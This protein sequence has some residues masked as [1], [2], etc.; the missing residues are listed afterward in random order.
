MMMK[1][2]KLFDY[3]EDMVRRVLEAFKSLRSVMAQMPTGTGKTYL[4]AAI[5]RDIAGQQVDPCVWIVAHRRELV[6]QIE[7]TLARFGISTDEH[8]VKALSI[9]WLSR[10]IDEVGEEPGM[11]VIDEAHH[12]LAETY[13][14]LWDKFPKTKFLGLTATPCRLN[15]KGFTDLFDTLVASYTVG[16]FIQMGYL[17]PFDYVS[18]RPNSEEQRLVDSLVKR[19]ADGDFQT[20]EMAEVLNT[21]PSIERLYRS[22][23]DFAGD[24]KGIVYAINI[25]HAHSIAEYYLEHGINAVAIDSKTPAEV[26]KRIIERFKKAHTD[27]TDLTDKDASIQVLVNVDIFSEGFDCPDVEFIQLARPT[28]SLAKYL[29]MVGRGLRVTKGKKACAIIDNVGLYRMF[30]LPTMP[31]NWQA[32]FHGRFY[33]KRI[34][35]YR[36]M[37]LR[38][39]DWE[40]LVPLSGSDCGDDPEIMVLMRHE[41][42]TDY[43]NTASGSNVGAAHSEKAH[44]SGEDYH[45]V[46]KKK[47]Y[48]VFWVFADGTNK[49]GLLRL[50]DKHVIMP[51]ICWEGIQILPDQ[52]ARAR[53]MGNG[54]D[55]FVDLVSE[56]IFEARFLCEL[57]ANVYSFGNISLLRVRNEF[58]TRTQKSYVT[59]FP[60]STDDI[61]FHG[62][63]LQINDPM[64]KRK[65]PV[66]VIEGDETQYYWL[67]EKLADK[68]ICVMTEEGK[69]YRVMPNGKKKRVRNLESLKAA[70]G[71]GD[72]KSPQTNSST[73]QTNSQSLLANSQ[74]PQANSQSSQS[75]SD[76]PQAAVAS[77]RVEPVKM[78]T[79]WGMKVDGKLF[80]APIYRN[81]K[82]L[83]DEFF[84]IEKLPGM[85]GIINIAGKVV[86]EPL[87]AKVELRDKATAVLLKV[88]G[89]QEAKK[90]R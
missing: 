27:S 29:Q 22:F 49:Y 18:I 65:M 35:D 62:F 56:R 20:K 69:Y 82:P 2:I 70:E 88:N 10:H 68:S 51:P 17:A 14:M 21:R 60:I 34:T 32:M 53:K 26:R 6:A 43:G 78:G 85:W 74:S 89:Q 58:Y 80:V 87:F 86:V 47:G 64:A 24:K 55:L 40:R 81:I 54:N 38:G 3:Q 76:F 71:I 61:S 23:R 90:L 1:N 73:L 41:Q 67:V 57:S 45:I 25:A 46:E 75:A 48:G 7:E 39:N 77:R 79:K 44:P 15:R 72:Y 59:V 4:L 16:K 13:K 9:Q 8:R 52:T 37:L 31:W 42:L 66:C 11:I 63:Y 19:G 12:A 84:A 33:R 36:Q 50:E 30:G 5:V 83:N 28:L